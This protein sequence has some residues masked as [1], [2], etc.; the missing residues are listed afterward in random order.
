MRMGSERDP[1]ENGSDRLL[2][3]KGKRELFIG[4]G[5][6]AFPLVLLGLLNINLGGGFFALCSALG[7]FLIVKAWSRELNWVI[8]KR[9]FDK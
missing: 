2:S 5:S 4:V 8:L 9:R 1:Q 3:Y 7:V 6:I